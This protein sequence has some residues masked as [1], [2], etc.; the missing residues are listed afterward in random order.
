MP[1]HLDSGVEIPPYLKVVAKIAAALIQQVIV[2]GI[3]LVHRHKFLKPLLADAVTFGTDVDRR[4]LVDLEDVVKAIS[5]G[6]V[7]PRDERDLR[8][9]VRVFLVM[10]AQRLERASYLRGTH[11]L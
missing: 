6:M 7:L 4:S 11:P 10:L 3:L 8:F 5:F 9:Q 2:D 1:L